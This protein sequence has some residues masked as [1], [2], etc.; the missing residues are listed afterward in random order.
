MNVSLKRAKNPMDWWQVYKLYR[1]AFPRSEQK[2]F[3]LI[4]KMAKTGKTDAWCIMEGRRFKGFAT[5][6]NGSDAVLLD[7]LAISKEARGRGFGSKA[8]AEMLLK[9]TGRGFFVEIESAFEPGED[10]ELRRRRRR[11]YQSA[12]LEAFGVMADVFGVKMELLGTGCRLN[13]AQYHDFYSTNYSPWA[14]E[15]LSELPYPETM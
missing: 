12:G 15:H 2:P 1:Q 5:T 9:Y 6:I 11:F 14:A 13:Y 10:L 3:S 7:Y 4:I 8:L